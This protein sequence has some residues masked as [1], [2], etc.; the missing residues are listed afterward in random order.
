MELIKWTKHAGFA[1]LFIEI[2]NVFPGEAVPVDEL[3]SCLREL[4]IGEWVYFY[5]LD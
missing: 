1:R 4:G 3:L 2:G 5:Q